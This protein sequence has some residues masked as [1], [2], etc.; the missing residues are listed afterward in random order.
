M[1]TTE[2]RF[3]TIALLLTAAVLVIPSPALAQECGQQCDECAGGDGYAGFDSHPFGFYNRL[4]FE[5][6]PYC[7][8]CPPAGFAAD[9]SS[10][11]DGLFE[12]IDAGEMKL[13]VARHGNRLLVSTERNL[14]VV[15]GSA[16][17]SDA[18]T[19]VSL[20][21]HDKAA[22]LAELGVR[23]LEEYMA[24]AATN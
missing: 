10:S 24:R 23:S 17:S 8:A 11:I 21:K 14:L 7:V 6:V 2:Q 9:G 16:C 22:V 20:L 5:E 1:L 19:A 4:C 15:Q 13:L 3:L 12:L 18:L